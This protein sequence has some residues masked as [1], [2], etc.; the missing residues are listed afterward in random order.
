MTQAEQSQIDKLK[1]AASEPNTDNDEQWVQTRA[2][3][4]GEA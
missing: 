4:A 2:R 3:K 1:E